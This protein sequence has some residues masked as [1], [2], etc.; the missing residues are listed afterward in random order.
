MGKKKE[1]EWV[2]SGGGV[3]VATKRCG[4]SQKGYGSRQ[5][6]EIINKAIIL[7]LSLKEKEKRLKKKKKSNI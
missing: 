1:I 6:L 2:Q 3:V 5:I 7:F 4:N